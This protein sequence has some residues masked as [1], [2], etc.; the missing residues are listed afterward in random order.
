MSV[1]VRRIVAIAM[2]MHNT[3]NDI[4]QHTLVVVVRQLKYILM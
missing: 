2:V 3:N 4:T 1:Y